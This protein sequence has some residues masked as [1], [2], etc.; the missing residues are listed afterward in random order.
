M[1]LTY[2]IDT[3]KGLVT[4]NGDYAEAADWRMLL[5]QI[6]R[7]PA[8]R[9]GL[10]FLR[11]LRRSSHPVSVEAV[12]GIIAVVRE[13]WARLGVKRAAIVT[14]PGIDVPAMI[15]HA[16]AECEHLPLQAFDFYD[17]A[18]EWLMAP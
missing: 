1:P 18:V 10:V 16:L 2:Q 3:V 15:A 17:D 7:D 14:G 8:C 4:I 11:D 9:P 5:T 12:V 6:A 13:L